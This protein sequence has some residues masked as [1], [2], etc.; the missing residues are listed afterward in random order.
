MS[1]K[2][3]DA[4]REQLLERITQAA[5]GTL[6]TAEREL[7]V[8]LGAARETVRRVIGDLVAEGRLVRRHGVGTFV[9]PPKMLHHL[10]LSSFTDDMQARGMK[11]GARTVAFERRLAGAQ[12]ARDLHVS[13]DERVVVANRLRLADDEP[14][15]LETLHVPD[16][17]V[18]G[19]APADLEDASFYDLL[20][21]RFAIVVEVA[22]QTI[23]PTVT[24]T[25]ESRHLDV[26]L[27]SPA[28]LFERTT[29]DGRGVVVE[30]VR[31]IYRGD[32]YRLAS[33]LRRPGS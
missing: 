27:H 31:S 8:E 6:L 3:R 20:S 7:A 30:F 13:P 23:E 16:R 9:A 25:D 19:L 32:R 24:S 28:L 11:P 5:P 4:I 17:L 29:R 22:E 15:A 12:I 26:P 2:K 14:I 33:T 10:H 18:P 1:R 21:R